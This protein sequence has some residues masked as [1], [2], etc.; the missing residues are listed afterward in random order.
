MEAFLD[1]ANVFDGDEIEPAYETPYAAW[2]VAG[3]LAQMLDFAVTFVDNAYSI[4][5]RFPKPQT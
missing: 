4:F 1:D 3:E 5:P 2:S